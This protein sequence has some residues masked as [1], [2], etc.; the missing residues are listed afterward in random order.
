MLAWPPGLLF[1]AVPRDKLRAKTLG[2]LAGLGFTFWALPGPCCWR[3]SSR[4]QQPEAIT[5]QWGYIP[6]AASSIGFAPAGGRAAGAAGQRL[7]ASAAARLALTRLAPTAAFAA[8]LLL[9]GGYL[10]GVE[11]AHTTMRRIW[12]LPVFVRSRSRPVWPMAWQKR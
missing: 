1:F 10:R 7:Y 6:A 11:G 4:Y 12:R 8:A 9:N 5:W 3:F 2:A